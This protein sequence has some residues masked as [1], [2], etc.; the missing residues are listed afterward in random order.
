M[1][2]APFCEKLR[3]VLKMLSMSA[4]ELASSLGTDKSAISRWLKGSVRPSAH[5][6][7]RLSALVAR[8]V[9]GFRTLD[10]ERDPEDLAEMFGVAPGTIP[11][12]RASRPAQGLP[13]AIWDQ[14]ITA[15]ALRG[16]A[17]EGFFRTTRAIPQMPGR[18]MHGH[19]M[20]RRDEIGLLRVTMGTG[21]T[22]MIDGWLLPM[23]GQL[24][25][26]AADVTSGTMLFGV[27]NGV[28]AARVDV[29]DGLVLNPGFGV[30][31]TP[32]AMAMI[33]ERVGDLS[34]DREAED[35]RL[36][37]LLTQPPLAA[38]GSIPEHIERHLVRDFGP[39]QLAL[40]GD[41]LLTMPLNRSMSR[42]P[43]FATPPKSET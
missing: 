7:S 23:Q 30:E 29:F 26:I 11:A 35:R 43:D 31:R 2:T 39:E 14:L 4:A 37:E 6:L 28:G 1:M 42:G 12:I 36:A 9:E 5:N 38:E 18:F 8:R 33:C 20:I 32:T 17:Y 16:K 15:A 22:I 41:W 3:L 34:G 25:C 40:G 27:F 24:Y 13:I 10:W 19:V 21:D